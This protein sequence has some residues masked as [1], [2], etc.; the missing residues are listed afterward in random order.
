MTPIDKL[1]GALA[2]PF[3]GNLIEWRVGAVNADKTR[4]QALPYTTARAI[5]DRLDDVMGPGGW[6]AK[7]R[8]VESDMGGQKLSAMFCAISLYIDGRWITKE[9]AVALTAV[10]DASRSHIDPVKTAVSDAFKRAAV[11]WGLGRYLYEFEAPWVAL[12][13]GGKYFAA[14]PSL[15]RHLLPEGDVSATKAGAPADAGGA[16]AA[17]SRKGARLTAVPGTEPAPAAA[18]AAPEAT[19]PEAAAERPRPAKA[20]AATEVPVAQPQTTEAPA[21]EAPAA[22]AT[23]AQG[24]VLSTLEGTAFETAKNVLERARTGKAPISL[25]RNYLN[26]DSAKK[27]FTGP[28]IVGLFTELEAIESELRAKAA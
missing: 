9:D 1:H 13:E 23:H 11:H 21:A 2:A 28:A 5:Q 3:P 8:V 17:D 10:S 18:A 27:L 14:Q 24:G 19:P 25:L 22:E 16:P 20:E 26:G 12:K 4:G 6:E 7:Y 15:P